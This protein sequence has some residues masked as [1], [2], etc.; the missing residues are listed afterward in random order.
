MKNDPRVRPQTVVFKIHRGCI[1]LQ[2]SLGRHR[3]GGIIGQTSRHRGVI[4]I[5]I[6]I[7]IIKIIVSIWDRHLEASGRHLEA[8]GSIWKHLDASG[9]IRR[10]LEASGSI[11]KH[12]DASGSILRHLEASGSIWMSLGGTWSTPGEL[13]GELWEARAT[14]GGPDASWTKKLS[15]HICVT[16]KS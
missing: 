12:L 2:A 10:H 4:V 16:I 13:W 11:W 6:I 14:T 3:G 1:M 8:S 15:K 9:S 5:I 7:V